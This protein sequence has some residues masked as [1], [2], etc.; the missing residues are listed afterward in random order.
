ML[1]LIRS[2]PKKEFTMAISHT[3]PLNPAAEETVGSLGNGRTTSVSRSDGTTVT[4]IVIDL[5]KKRRKQ[6]RALKRGSGKLMDEVAEVL[7]RVRESLG[8][9]AELKNLVPVVMIYRQKDKR[10][11]GLLP[12]SF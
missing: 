2:V 6:I 5:G 1:L 3:T 10:R 9:E 7:N 11:G 4:P 8:T 12:L